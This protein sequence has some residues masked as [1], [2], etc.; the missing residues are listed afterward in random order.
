MIQ[1]H[2]GH[3]L[4]PAGVSTDQ[5]AHGV[6]AA[7]SLPSSLTSRPATKVHMGGKLPDDSFLFTTIVGLEL[8]PLGYLEY[9][10]SEG[11]TI[12]RPPRQISTCS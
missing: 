10:V 11:H 1:L 8:L 5:M 4:T 12:F 2:S 3:S 7:S 9:L 6:T